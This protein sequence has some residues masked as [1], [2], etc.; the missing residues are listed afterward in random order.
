MN[1]D[2]VIELIQV[3]ENRS[4]KRMV[5]IKEYYYDVAND[6]VYINHICKYDKNNK[7]WLWN[8]RLYNDGD[9][10]YNNELKE[11]LAVLY[12]KYPLEEKPLMPGYYRS[13]E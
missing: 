2:I 12:R 3:P 9:D 4:Q 5:G 6:R 11:K 8:Y 7:R 13:D 10:E 1:F